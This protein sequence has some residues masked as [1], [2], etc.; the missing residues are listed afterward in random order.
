[1]FYHR[2]AATAGRGMPFGVRPFA[3]LRVPAWP[4]VMLSE[5]KHPARWAIAL[6][7]TI[8]RGSRMKPPPPLYGQSLPT[9]V[10]N[11]RPTGEA[12]EGPHRS[13]RNHM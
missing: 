5:A 12:G 11:L 6:F 8:R 10:A 9:P 7:M 13:S 4:A 1:V 3:P 2:V